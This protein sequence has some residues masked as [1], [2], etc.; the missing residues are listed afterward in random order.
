VLGPVQEKLIAATVAD[1]Q[2]MID[3]V[4]TTVC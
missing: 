3:A 4:P 2:R 1:A